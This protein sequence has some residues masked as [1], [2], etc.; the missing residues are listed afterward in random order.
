ML[1]SR[2]QAPLVPLCTDT[3]CAKPRAALLAWLVSYNASPDSYSSPHGGC[4]QYPWALFCSLRIAGSGA[5]GSPAA[6]AR[7]SWA[8]QLKAAVRVVGIP[9]SYRKERS[10]RACSH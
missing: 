8:A 5:E 10:V 9:E 4:L 7:I 6:A 2:Q 1:N 3:G